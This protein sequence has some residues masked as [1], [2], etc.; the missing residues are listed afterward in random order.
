MVQ[1]RVIAEPR[2]VGMGGKPC[3]CTRAGRLRVTRGCSDICHCHRVPHAECPNAEPC[4]GCGRLTSRAKRKPAATARTAR[5]IA[6]GSRSPDL[7]HNLGKLSSR[8][9]MNRAALC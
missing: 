8:P 3:Q 7:I 4:I 6:G 2:Q 1:L 5:P 9:A